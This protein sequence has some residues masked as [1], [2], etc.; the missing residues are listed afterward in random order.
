MKLNRNQMNRKQNHDPSHRES[1]KRLFTFFVVLIKIKFQT[2]K[3][4]N[5]RPRVRKNRSPKTES[6][7]EQSEDNSD[8]PEE[9]PPSKKKK[10]LTECK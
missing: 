5:T 9:Q 3:S 1:L 7:D 6:E 10:P 4:N 8:E 2:G